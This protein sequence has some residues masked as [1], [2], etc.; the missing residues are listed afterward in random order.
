MIN[1][2]TIPMKIKVAAGVIAVVLLAL[3]TAYCV[4][5]GDGKSKIELEI[6]KANVEALETNA[7]ALGNAADDRV[8]S[9]EQILKTKEELVDVVEAT[10]DSLP[11]ATRIALGCERLRRQGTD[12]SVIPA[13]SGR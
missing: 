9:N 5:R 12:T 1:L 4:G 7:N 8:V 2:A 10:P 6:E 11:S 13:C 3:L